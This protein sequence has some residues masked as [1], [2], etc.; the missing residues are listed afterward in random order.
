M[1]DAYNAHV[2]RQPPNISLTDFIA[3]LA[4]FSD[5]VSAQAAGGSDLLS[6]L[7]NR[8]NT[9]RRAMVISS[10]N[11]SD[12]LEQNNNSIINSH[13]VPTTDTDRFDQP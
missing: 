7:L 9:L 1:P 12:E 2:G 11:K 6:V 10:L 5:V 4:S 13:K 3:Y 8:G